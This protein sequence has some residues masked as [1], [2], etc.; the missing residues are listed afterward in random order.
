MLEGVQEEEEAL[1]GCWRGEA[2]SKGEARSQLNNILCR[3]RG[4][5]RVSP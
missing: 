2:R 5:A 1:P 4:P 3:T